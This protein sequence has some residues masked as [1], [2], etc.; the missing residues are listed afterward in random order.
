MDDRAVVWVPLPTSVNEEE[1][2]GQD[3]RKMMSS[4]SNERSS[5]CRWDKLGKPL[6]AL[7]TE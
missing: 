4:E 1:N 2:V 5:C 3:G 6:M 7:G